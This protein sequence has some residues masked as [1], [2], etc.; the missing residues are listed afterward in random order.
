MKI[1]HSTKQMLEIFAGV[2]L[3]GSILTNS[4]KADTAFINGGNRQYSQYNGWCLNVTANGAVT[5][6]S[7]KHSGC[8][9]NISEID[10][11]YNYQGQRGRLVQLVNLG[12]SEYNGWYLNVRGDSGMV[13]VE[14]YPH[15]GTRWQLHYPFEDVQVPSPTE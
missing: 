3:I 13:T 11:N 8:N 10:G 5:M 9:W 15:S 14:S 1:F 6:E 4:V 12:N 2:L 7:T